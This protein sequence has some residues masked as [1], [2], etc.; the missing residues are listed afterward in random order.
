MTKYTD[1]EGKPVS[2]TDPTRFVWY[3]I[4]G[5]GYWTDDQSKLT[6]AG[7]PVCPHCGAPG[8]QTTAGQWD[9]SVAEYDAK[10]PGYAA[11]V[12]SGKEKCWRR[13][14]GGFNAAWNAARQGKLLTQWLPPEGDG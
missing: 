6:R 11:F 8:M 3:G 7:I 14:E 2:A 4:R 1:T 12:S 9:S 5:C 10:N 13:T